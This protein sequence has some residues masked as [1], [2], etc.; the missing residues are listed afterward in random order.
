M[1][2]EEKF[3]DDLM[4]LF[5]IKEK[6]SLNTDLLDIENW[7][8]FSAVSFLVM[9]EEKYGVKA[10][11]FEIAEAIYVEDLYNIVLKN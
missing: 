2:S 3:V 10:E 7:D 4:E 11:P 6:I 5:E 8:S 1:P 9:V